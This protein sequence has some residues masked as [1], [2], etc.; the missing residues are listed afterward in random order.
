MVRRSL[1]TLI[2]LAVAAACADVPTPPLENVPSP[3]APGGALRS[4]SGIPRSGHYIVVFR[5][6]VTDTP[7]RA[8][9]L[10]AAEGGTL[11]FTYLHTIH[12]FAAAL[13]PAAIATLKYHPDIAMI[14]PDQVV[15]AIT[16]QSNAT[17]GLD[18]IDQANLPLD[19][20]YT[21]TATGSGVNAYIIDTGIR[22]THSE[23]GGRASGVFTA[24]NDGNGTNDCSGHG[25]HV[26]GTVGG[27]TYGVAKSVKLYAVRVLD[28]SGN[29]P[30]SG[31][32]AGV[33]WV[34]ANHK[35]PAVANMSLGGSVS[36]TLDQAVQSSI[37]SGVT[38]AIAAGNASA[39]A[40]TQSPARTPQAITVAATTSTDARASFSNYGTCVDIFAPGE[41]ITSA[42][43]GS[44]NQTAVLSG[45]SMATP[46]VTGV[47]ALYLE[48]N[49]NATPAAVA[50]AITG[51]AIAN[52]VTGPGTG[53][54]NRLLNTSFIGGGSGPNNPPVAKFTWSC[55]TLTCTFDATSSTDDK[56]IVSYSWDLNKYPGGTAAGPVLSATYPH[57]DTR[58]VTLTVTDAGGL[59]NSVTQTIVIGSTPPNQAPVAQFGS[60]CTNLACTFDSSGSS[61][62]VGITNR[63]WTFGDGSSAGN[64]VSP[65]HTYASAGTYNVTLTVT[66]AG[67]LTRSVTKQVTVTAPPQPNQPPVARFTWSCPTLTCTFDA[68]SSTD[69]KGIVSYTWDLNKYLNGTAT[70]SLVSTTYPHADTRYVKLTVTDAGGLSS[71]VTQTIIIGSTPSQ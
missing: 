36:T 54:P 56:G 7:E 19:N 11:E 69:D 42:Y 29:G 43:N 32:I 45:T 23:F 66:D 48:R 58:Y 50:T 47:A 65:S 14:E 52:K 27:S 68:T 20:S 51:G 35:S 10:V 64:V 15:T 8:Q 26:A 44:D 57:P 63:T 62:D 18:R 1:L 39:D 16:T 49:P 59:S 61:D 71:S 34:T 9:A 67:S 70:G 38:Y 30:V 46:H 6:H 21:Y 5:N 25:T 22:T 37:A 41:S 13:S 53:S 55:P 60:S 2:A 3:L 28:C 17:W 4:I 31:V 40:C 33:D 24:V 12:G